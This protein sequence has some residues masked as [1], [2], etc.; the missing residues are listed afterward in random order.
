MTDKVAV[1]DIGSY[2]TKVGFS[3]T[4][5]PT[6]IIPSIADRPLESSRINHKHRAGNDADIY[7]CKVLPILVNGKVT[8]WDDFEKLIKNSYDILGCEPDENPVLITE[9]P[10][11]LRSHR[12][13]YCPNYV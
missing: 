12:E 7:H 11:S 6:G 13:K 5:K 3:G 2:E 10:T 4:D 9:S 1:F 8:N